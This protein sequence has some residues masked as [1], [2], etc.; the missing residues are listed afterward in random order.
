MN[1]KQIL[2]FD[3]FQ[4]IL[5]VFLSILIANYLYL[6]FI[7]YTKK[8][9]GIDENIG[10]EGVEGF[11]NEDSNSSALAILGNDH[12]FDD[13]YAQV[14]DQLV[15]GKTRTKAEVTYTLNW[16]KSYRPDIKSIEVLDIGCG[17][18][19]GVDE[20]KKAGVSKAV[21][22][23]RA[24]SMIAKGRKQFS[25]L[26][27]RVGD[28][29]IIGTCS[30]NEF[31]VATLFYFTF[32]YLKDR[33]TALRNIY[34]WL[35]MGSCLVIHL[36][37]RD[38]FDPILESASPFV[39][40]SLQKY[41]KD[42]ITQS[43]VSFD[44]FDYFANFELEG[45]EAHF[46]EEFKFKDG[47]VRRQIHRL[48]MPTMDETVAIVERCGFTYKQFIDLTPIGYEYQYLFCFVK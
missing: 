20:F 25:S 40:F 7:V 22:I 48:R 32:Y 15:D 17:T 2:S 14:Y 36:V 46:K 45:S 8:Y 19:I 26:D 29:E 35:Q 33:E 30:S 27:L 13:F 4:I 16:V 23:D 39:G 41:S 42:R 18:G 5:V 37:N 9:S 38:K 43:K 44:K 34:N 21:G 12:I 47:K 24:E 6:R 10:F 31:N 28:A 3:T 11:S 1:F